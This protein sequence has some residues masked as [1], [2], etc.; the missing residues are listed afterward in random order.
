MHK[1]A[2][3]YLEEARPLPD[4]WS[5]ALALS[6]T[7]LEFQEMLLSAAHLKVNPARK[8]EILTLPDLEP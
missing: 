2:L 4:A 6:T 5:M 3:I 8:P 7:G 1:H